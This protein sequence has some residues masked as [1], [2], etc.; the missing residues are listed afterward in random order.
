MCKEHINF[1]V[2][3]CSTPLMAVNQRSSNCLEM[4]FCSFKAINGQNTP[5]IWQ[6]QQFKKTIWTHF[7]KG[8]V[9]GPFRR[10]IS[11]N[12][13]WI[14]PHPP[15]PTLIRL[16][17]V[18]HFIFVHLLNAYANME[19][20]KTSYQLNLFHTS[21]CSSKSLGVPEFWS[22]LLHNFIIF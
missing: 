21:L 20:P 2:W 11:Q 9:F 6:C 16:T 22:G 19:E 15:Q 1:R 8:S 17:F 14:T 7:V 5:T 10:N 18:W 13:N 4:K 3:P 12:L